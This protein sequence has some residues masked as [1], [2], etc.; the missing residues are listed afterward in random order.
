MCPFLNFFQAGSYPGH[1]IP[2]P[3]FSPEAKITYPHLDIHQRKPLVKKFGNLVHT[4][5]IFANIKIFNKISIFL[6]LEYSHSSLWK[7]N[8]FQNSWNWI[9]LHLQLCSKSIILMK[10][11]ILLHLYVGVKPQFESNVTSFQF[12]Q[13]ASPYGVLMTMARLDVLA[14]INPFPTLFTYL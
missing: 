6:K 4:A 13:N 14:G 8:I 3:R 1:F 5:Q 2:T 7:F 10:L 12:L 11:N 9:Y